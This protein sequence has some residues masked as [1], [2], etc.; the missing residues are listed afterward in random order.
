MCSGMLWFQFAIP[1]VVAALLVRVEAMTLGPYWA[2]VEM[3]SD[4]GDDE[5]TK[6]RRRAAL[7]RRVAVPGVTAFA[8]IAVWPNS[9]TPAD[10][11]WVGGAAAGLLLWPLLFHGL[12][13]G[14]STPRL[15]LLYTALVGA[16]VAS[17]WFGGEIAGFAHAE[18]GVWE[19][20]KE[21]AISMV[22]G[23]VVTL[24]ASAVVSRS[25]TDASEHRGS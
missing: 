22:A 8:L 25:S 9:F 21:N 13:W 14:V 7:A 6:K 15:V 5:T 24:F 4:M 20:F 10:T 19:F 17:G 2:W 3:L 23:G 12:P 16:F 11:A 18:G 1:A